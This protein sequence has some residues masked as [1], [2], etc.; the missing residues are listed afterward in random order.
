[1]DVGPFV[2]TDAQTSELI[3]PSEGSRD[4]PVPPPKRACNNLPA[5]PLLR[6]DSSVSSGGWT[7][8]RQH[9]LSDANVDVALDHFE[10]K[11]GDRPS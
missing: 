1:M 8:V 11:P 5:R 3:Q 10:I 9:Q 7:G 4:D 2:V 6:R